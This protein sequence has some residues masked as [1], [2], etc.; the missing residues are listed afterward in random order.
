MDNNDAPFAVVAEAVRPVAGEPVP[1]VTEPVAAAVA[2]TPVPAETEPLAPAAVTELL[3]AAVT[4]VPAVTE[5]PV[6]AEP[7][8]A[9]VSA[10]P[11]TAPEAVAASVPAPVAA[12]LDPEVELLPALVP[13]DG[14][15]TLAVD[16]P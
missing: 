14:E 15:L 7:V 9:R 13:L 1:A 2:L 6:S 5:A 16:V 11:V 4:P 10:E 12:A 3:A 8:T